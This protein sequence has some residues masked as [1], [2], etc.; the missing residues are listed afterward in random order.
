MTR[1]LPNEVPPVF[2]MCRNTMTSWAFKSNRKSSWRTSSYDRPGWAITSGS[3]RPGASP[4]VRAK[5][6]D[7]RSRGDRAHTY[8]Q[9]EKS[10]YTPHYYSIFITIVCI[11]ISIKYLHKFQFQFVFLNQ[12]SFL[13][14]HTHVYIIILHIL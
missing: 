5:D 9:K 12:L 10:Y 6:S 14:V 7:T 2:W 13:Y 11:F 8:G 4:Y 1:C 3:G